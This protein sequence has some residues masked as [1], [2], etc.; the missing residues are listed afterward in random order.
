MIHGR[1]LFNFQLNICPS[2]V[3]LSISLVGIVVALQKYC[4]R[5]QLYLCLFVC[6]LRAVDFND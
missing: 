1:R 6:V 4:F 5:L 3:Y 2:F